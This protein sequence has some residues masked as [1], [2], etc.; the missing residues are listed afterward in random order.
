MNKA[1]LRKEILAV[2]KSVS[3]PALS[4]QICDKAAGL[5]VFRR[6]KTIMIYLP[7]GSEVDTSRL[8]AH[9][10]SA[11]KKVCAPKVLCDTEMEAVYIDN[12]GF[13]MGRFQ[14]WEPMGPP[15]DS[16]DLVFVPGAVFDPKGHRI[17]YGRGYYD[18][19][20]QNS[21]ACKVGLCYACQMVPLIPAEPHDV[22]LDKILTE[23]KI[24]P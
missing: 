1:H 3:S 7:T 2:R 23:D 11:G 17:G 22:R 14:I 6:A 20:L 19:F 13:Q 24:Y 18:R 10:L 15:A 4:A 8:L 21:A 16:I 12:T 9:A 5:D